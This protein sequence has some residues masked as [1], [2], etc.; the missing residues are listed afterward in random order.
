MKVDEW[1]NLETVKNYG[2]TGPEAAHS[3]QE[4]TDGN[5]IVTD[6]SKSNDEDVGGKNGNFDYWILKL[7]NEC[8][9]NWTITS[10]TPFQNIYQICGAITT[11]G[12]LT[13]EQN[14]SEKY[15]ANRVALSEGFSAKVGAD[16]KVRNSECQ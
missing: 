11:N 7:N 9:S 2:G 12:F 5:Y 6:S 3:I 16:F 13:I 10:N 14:Q 4:T 8:L 15:C 1:G